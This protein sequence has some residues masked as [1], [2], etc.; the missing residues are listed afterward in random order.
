MLRHQRPLGARQ[1]NGQMPGS[2]L[3]PMAP[4]NENYEKMKK[5]PLQ[6]F[7]ENP[8][9]EKQKPITLK[10]LV[11]WTPKYEGFCT[12]E[13]QKGPKMDQKGPK[14]IFFRFLLNYIFLRIFGWFFQIFLTIFDH[15]WFL[16]P[17]DQLWP[18][19]WKLWENEKM[20]PYNISQKTQKRKNKKP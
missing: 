7:P 9:T 12:Q 6:Y 5:C 10:R 8:K 3:D 14:M 13:D 4:K 11:G 19:K 15:S 18:Q 17:W 20:P 1:R 2:K 16:E